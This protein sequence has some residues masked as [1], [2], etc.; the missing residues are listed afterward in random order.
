M[1]GGFGL[2]VLCGVL[3]LGVHCFATGRFGL[4]GSPGAIMRSMAGIMICYGMVYETFYTL[5]RY[6]LSID[7][8]V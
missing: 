4:L 5:Y 8:K 1:G 3:V 7:R 2:L 6:L